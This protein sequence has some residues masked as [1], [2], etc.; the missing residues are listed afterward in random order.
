MK[1]L[2]STA[3]S[4]IALMAVE[5]IPQSLVE[6]TSSSDYNCDTVNAT[7]TGVCG[8]LFSAGLGGGRRK[9]RHL[10]S[11]EDNWMTED[12]KHCLDE[13]YDTAVAIEHGHFFFVGIPKDA[14]DCPTVVTDNG[15]DAVKNLVPHV[16]ILGSD[17]MENQTPNKDKLFLFGHAIT[18]GTYV[19]AINDLKSFNVAKADYD[20]IENNCST[21]MFEICK[22]VG[23]DYKELETLANIEAFVG[24]S[25]A[26][27][28]D[29]V[30][31]LRA[32][33]LE[34]NEGLY[35]TAKFRVWNWYVGDEEMT[36]HFVKSYMAA[37]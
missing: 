5:L 6:A 11:S 30:E 35:E 28:T 2:K 29:V 22:K 37:H 24:K 33:Y 17:E 34:H 23:I 14:P 9:R 26:A 16:T 10:A 19:D 4:L 20:V 31:M 21:L 36:R 7:D 18:L 3:L 12:I 1:I 27:D 32:G 8:G 25:I 15:P 13:S